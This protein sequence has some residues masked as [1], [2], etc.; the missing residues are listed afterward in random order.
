MLKYFVGQKKRKKNN[1]KQIVIKTLSS[2]TFFSRC[3]EFL[4]LFWRLLIKVEKELI[5][6]SHLA[7][8]DLRIRF[9]II[10]SMSK[11]GRTQKTITGGWPLL[12]RTLNRASRRIEHY[13]T[14]LIKTS[15]VLI[16]KHSR[17]RDHDQLNNILFIHSMQSSNIEGYITGKVETV[18]DQIVKRMFELD[19]IRRSDLVISRKIFG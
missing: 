8:T 18:A 12:M 10:S 4:F 17:R 16:A 5:E 6:Y 15:F 3:L 14:V 19:G 13:A 1:K 11:I 2:Y 7:Q 9:F